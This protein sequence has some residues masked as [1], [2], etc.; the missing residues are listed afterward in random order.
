MSN[1]Q[2]AALIVDC[3]MLALYCIVTIFFTFMLVKVCKTKDKVYKH[4]FI[5]LV[6]C[7]Q[8][9]AVCKFY[10]I[11]MI[12]DIFVLGWALYYAADVWSYYTGGYIYK[13]NF[14]VLNTFV[15]V[16]RQISYLFLE[17][18]MTVNLAVWV[19]FFMKI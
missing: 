8:L 12:I 6:V 3:I 7:L 17:L 9:T 1:P 16:I 15:I 4:A 13:L 11:F 5:S 14:E 18:A 10:F 2:K 19:Y